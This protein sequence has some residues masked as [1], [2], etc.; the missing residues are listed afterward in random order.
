M[1]FKK[2]L[3]ILA[4]LFV[5]ISCNKDKDKEDFDR[6]A[7]LDNMA[8]AVI[9]PQLNSFNEDVI[10]LN[11][12]A[13]TYT[14]NTNTTNLQDLRSKY[15]IAYKSFQKCKMFDFGPMS[16][17]FIKS[18]MN[19]YPTDT[20]QIELN[21]SQGSVDVNAASNIDAI[22]FPAIDY[23]LY[24]Q[25][26]ST[27]APIDSFSTGTYAIERCNYLLAITGKMK[28]EMAI[29]VSNWNSYKTTFINADGNDVGSSTSLLFNEMV[30]DIELLKNAKIGIPAGQQTG[31]QTLPKYVEGYYA[32]ISIDLASENISALKNVFLG[33][34]GSGFDD[35]IKDVESEDVTTSLADNIA[36][37]FDV[38]QASIN[39]IGSPL[40]VK[41]DTNPTAV[42]TAYLEIKKLLTYCKTDMSSA[43]GLLITFQDNDG[44]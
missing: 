28:T 36:T 23:L 33:S 34:S 44:D 27:S 32:Q 40:S 12:A 3:I 14:A 16:D 13:L 21:I 30:K 41:V 2:S 5:V 25:H 15:A 6:K 8:S 35:Y 9:I 11:T 1:D 31:G 19:T 43:L 42:N 4:A 29:V 10:S 39:N 7:M 17:Q 22:G 26:Q 18:S 20:V 24:P 38:V 37:Q